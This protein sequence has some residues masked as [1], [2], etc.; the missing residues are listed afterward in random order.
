MVD[1]GL[2]LKILA[3]VALPGL[4]GWRFSHAYRT[5][6][7][8][9]GHILDGFAA[10]LSSPRVEK[11]LQGLPRLKGVLDG[12]PLHVSLNAD[13]LALR[14]LPTL[15]LEARWARDHGAVVDVLLEPSGTEYFAEDIAFDTRVEPPKGWPQS[16]IVRA[17]GGEAAPVLEA[18]A[19]VDPAS[20][21]ALK[22]VLLDRH[23]TRVVM[24]CARA[25]RQTYRVLRSATFKPDA[26][27]PELVEQTIA[28]LRS[29]EDPL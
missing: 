11:G 3:G 18:L 13:T 12:R 9:R 7:V 22:Y 4:L 27:T 24:K 1:P 8:A 20:F 6:R 5:E 10:A 23:E 16:T 19:Q 14:T 17:S 29:I 21:P 2:A 28:A 25:D 26:V 15:W